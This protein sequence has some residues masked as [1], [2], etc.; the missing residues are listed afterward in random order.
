MRLTA[1]AIS[2]IKKNKILFLVILIAI[3]LRFVGL[4]PNILHADESYVQ[5]HSWDLVKNFI[6]SRDINPHT[7][8][9]GTLM[10][11]F[12][13]IGAFPVL[14]GTYLL[15]IA[16]TLVSSTFTAKWLRFDLFYGEA[17]RKYVI[18]L[19]TV[20]RAET[21]F[22]GVASV[23]VVYLIGKKMFNKRVGI[24]SALFLAIAPL[25]TRDSHYITT[26]V[27]SV[28][29][30]L[31]AFLSFLYLYKTK[32][33]KWF[34]TSG[35]LMGI[36]VTV[37]YYPIAI[38]AYLSA[39][40]Y[41]FEKQKKWFRNILISFFFVLVGV[42]IGLPFLFLDSQGPKLFISDL[43][44]YALP[45]Y[46][47]P[48]TN[49]IFS[50]FVSI[51]SKGK[52]SLP[53]IHLLYSMPHSFRPVH[54]SWIFFNAYG[55]L[56]TILAIFAMFTLAIKSFKKFILL[57]SIPLINFF[58]ISYLIPA[59]YER[60]IIPTLPFLAIFTAI[61]LENLY[62]FLKEHWSKKTTK[63][64][65]L[66]SILLVSILP[67]SKA[68]EASITCSQETIQNQSY[69]WVN[70][71]I[72]ENVNIGYLTMVSIPPKKFG[73]VALEPG[74][75]LSLEEAMIRKNDYAF[76]NASRL[77]YN[78]YNYFNSFFIPPDKI[79]ENSY[80][81]LVISEYE[82]R[83][84]V[85]GRVQKPWMCDVSR[86]YYYQLPQL[87]KE[88]TKLIKNFNFDSSKDL[89]SWHITIPDNSGKAN[90]N[91]TSATGKQK[92]GSL[93]YFQDSFAYTA[94]R[95]ASNNQK[96]SP[97]KTYTFSFWSKVDKNS[98]DQSPTV[99][100][101]I[102]FYSS[103][104]PTGLEKFKQVLK[105]TILL[106]KE[107]PT[108]MYFEKKR[109]QTLIFDDI[110]LP[111]KMLAFS[112][113]TKLNSKWQK[114]SITTKAPEGVDFA[115]FSIQPISTQKDTINIDDITFATQ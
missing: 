41:S 47:T 79:F 93:I 59:T 3:I 38:F 98:D 80:Y 86:I 52:E 50:I 53:S 39:I 37:R 75:K 96:I 77:D 73:W 5:D 113:L 103:I 109:Q 108:P 12:Q 54:A 16:N 17:I 28:L 14:V 61:C 82:S 84:K 19:V 76:I 81:S 95:I 91:L 60:L 88:A 46:S 22:F 70:K 85:L 99:I 115:I 101:R 27:L 104:K 8:K 6:V 23:I 62:L 13:T 110:D 18:P 111:G 55:I 49:Y 107:G 83:A 2:F 33:L 114:I 4:M 87:A 71:S 51:I 72:P 11:Y 21:A 35:I 92:N 105:N 40:L 44:K 94:P 43:Q 106:V 64:A 1:R 102:D 67:F 48:I 9:Y 65:F 97:N 10:F 90:I 63:I 32:K 74:Q 42:F 100:A 20:G 31:L 30:I 68:L 89:E 29:T 26:D 7:F 45:W 34:I 56:P 36:S 25:H 15:E 78:T 69:D 112:S 58:Y 57:A 24:I 66:V